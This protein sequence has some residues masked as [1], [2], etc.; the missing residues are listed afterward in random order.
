MT[1]ATTT[2]T[3]LESIERRLQQMYRDT[4]ALEKARDEAIEG[5]RQLREE[6]EEQGVTRCNSDVETAPAIS[7]TQGN[8]TMPV[9]TSS[10]LPEGNM[11]P[12]CN[13][14]AVDSSDRS[15]EEKLRLPVSEDFSD[16]AWAT[17]AGIHKCSKRECG[18][19]S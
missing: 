17:S 13:V 19:G 12:G 6:T 14:E 3:E 9:L 11:H 1:E 8:G 10:S 2:E 16:R 18:E 7:D 15:E 5:E 4:N